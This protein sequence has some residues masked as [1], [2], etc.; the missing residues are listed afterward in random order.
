MP[1]QSFVAI[2]PVSP[3]VHWNLYG[4]TPPIGLICAEPLQ[5]PKQVL[6]MG[7]IVPTSM[8]S[9]AVMLMQKVSLQPA[10]SATVT[11]LVPAHSSLAVWV[12]FAVRPIVGHVAELARRR[13]RRRSVAIDFI[14]VE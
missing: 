1:E 13:H 5:M 6:A 12:R 3:L 8:T 2:W 7:T 10:A 9:G 4:G 14:T 11:Q